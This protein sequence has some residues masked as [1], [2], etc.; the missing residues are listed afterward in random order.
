MNG[1][2][3]T[4][5][6]TYLGFLCAFLQGTALDNTVKFEAAILVHGG[7]E[8]VQNVSSPNADICGIEGYGR[9]QGGYRHA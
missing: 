5:A 7:R 8:R 6:K 9:A 1:C 3:Y 2:H 4:Q